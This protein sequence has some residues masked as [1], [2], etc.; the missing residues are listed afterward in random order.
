MSHKKPQTIEEL[1]NDRIEVLS[2]LAALFGNELER[3]GRLELRITFKGDTD[4]DEW[5]SDIATEDTE[6]TIDLEAVTPPKMKKADFKSVRIKEPESLSALV[7]QIL[8]L[9]HPKVK[10]VFGSSALYTILSTAATAY[11]REGNSVEEKING[12][13]FA[14]AAQAWIIAKRIFVTNHLQDSQ[15]M[16]D[17]LLKGDKTAEAIMA[18]GKP[19]VFEEATDEDRKAVT[20]YCL[21]IIA[22]NNGENPE[23]ENE[24]KIEAPDEALR[25]IS[26]LQSSGNIVLLQAEVAR[27]IIPLAKGQGVG[28]T[29]VGSDRYPVIVKASIGDKN[30]KQSVTLTRTDYDVMEAVGQIVQE[31]GKGVIITPSQ[32]YQKIA[33]TDVD[34]RPSPQ[35]IDEIVSSMDKLLFTPATIDFTQQIEKHTKLKAKNKEIKDGKVKGS[36]EGNIISGLHLKRFSTAY[37]GQTVEHSFLIYDMPM[38]YYYSQTIKQLVTI[39]GYRLSGGAPSSKNE[40]KKAQKQ[41]TTSQRLT[42]KEVSLRRYLLERIEYC[43]RLRENKKQ[44]A[45]SF[46]F[47]TIAKD[48]GYEIDTPKRLRMLREQTYEF[49]KQQ[50]AHKNIKDCEYYYK[51]RALSG[52]T[53]IL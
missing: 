45:F 24:Q 22:Q 11:G 53:I 27:K 14:M 17:L 34:Y 30:G 3:Y 29:N 49:L 47:E 13:S 36:L 5:F 20:E 23:S 8:T 9:L 44:H 1:K 52:I 25:E 31:N 51:G 50:A 19:I 21:S 35:A 16:L 15:R 6:P 39:P 26:E 48:I 40:P 12:M 33:F 28:T 2:S 42:L 38:F 32:I 43:K 7:A 18:A 46:A 41:K 10:A 4:H 37:R